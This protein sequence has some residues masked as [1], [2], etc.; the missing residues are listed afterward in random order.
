MLYTIMERV[1]VSKK[2]VADGE[3]NVGKQ[4]FDCFDI[5]FTSDHSYKVSKIIQNIF[6]TVIEHC[7]ITCFR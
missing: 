4:S 1:K 5:S 2:T 6:S 3:K 7:L